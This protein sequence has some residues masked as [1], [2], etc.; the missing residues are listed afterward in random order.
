MIRTALWVLLTCCPPRASRAVG[1]DPQVRF[2][3][4][5]VYLV[6]R[7]HHVNGGKT[8]LPLVVGIEG[9][10]PDKTMGANLALEIPEGESALDLDGGALDPRLFARLLVEDLDVVIVLLQPAKVHALEHLRP[11]HRVNAPGARVD[12]KKH[13]PPVIAT[14]EKRLY[15]Q[16][17]Q[18]SVE[19]GGLALRLLEVIDVRNGIA[20]LDDTDLVLEI[21][22]ERKIR[23]GNTFD[24]LEFGDQRLGGFLVVPEVAR[25]HLL[26]DLADAGL[27]L[28][29]LKE[30]PGGIRG[31]REAP[32]TGPSTRFSFSGTLSQKGQK[33]E[34]YAHAQ[35]PKDYIV[36]EGALPGVAFRNIRG[37]LISFR[38]G[39]CRFLRYIRH[40]GHER[41]LGDPDRARFRRGPG[42]RQDQ[43]VQQHQGPG[44]ARFTQERHQPTSFLGTRG[45]RLESKPLDNHL[46]LVAS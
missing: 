15:L 40:D 1:I 19:G 37:F 26:F 13:G 10:D 21:A 20:Y 18:A 22:M 8:G 32:L 44:C 5:D 29:Y 14:G 39:V 7:G 33:Q 17:I 41:L 38:G 36:R 28:I 2:V 31:A 35:C 4:I 34:H 27:L 46:L 3:D 42:L 16:S 23:L 6:V 30:S 12:R 9:G 11:V 25:R 45:S 43:L 24:G